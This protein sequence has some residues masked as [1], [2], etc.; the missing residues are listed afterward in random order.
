MT[1]Q[2]KINQLTIAYQQT[3]NQRF[4][5][6]LTKWILLKQRN[7][8]FAKLRAEVRTNNTKWFRDH[9][10]NLFERGGGELRN[11]SVT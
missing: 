11:M 9:Q 10:T 8:L 4:A 1:I 7:E 6:S 3:G 5:S 2:E